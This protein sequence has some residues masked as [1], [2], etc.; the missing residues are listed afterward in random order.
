MHLTRGLPV[1]VNNRVIPETKLWRCALLE[2]VYIRLMFDSAAT[3]TDKDVK[4]HNTIII[5]YADCVCGKRIKTVRCPSVV[6][7]SARA[8]AAKPCSGGRCASSAAYDAQAA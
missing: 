3:L 6:P 4:M 8:A 2:T 1:I 7:G 5:Y